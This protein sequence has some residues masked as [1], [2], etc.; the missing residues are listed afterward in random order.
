MI[1][2]PE[3]IELVGT[4]SFPTAV[5]LEART[6]VVTTALPRPR[7]VT[8][9]LNEPEWSLPLPEVCDFGKTRRACT[10]F[11]GFP[12]SIPPSTVCVDRIIEPRFVIDVS[13]LLEMTAGTS[14]L[15]VCG[16][17][18]IDDPEDQFA[19][20]RAN[21]SLVWDEYTRRGSLRFRLF[22]DRLRPSFLAAP[23]A[24]TIVLRTTGGVRV[25]SV[26]IP[27][28]TAE[29]QAELLGSIDGTK[30]LWCTGALPGS[31]HAPKELDVGGHGLPLRAGMLG[32]HVDVLG[33]PAVGPG[34]SVL[35]RPA[36]AAA[37]SAAA[38][39][40]DPTSLVAL[41]RKHW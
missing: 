4:R 12:P 11:P 2:E 27:P 18:V 15:H 9:A 10:V 14:A 7:L 29:V 34:P 3:V 23:Y 36:A 6:K 28:L 19:K 33:R 1:T 25:L 39:V 26:P 24:A 30:K 22:H 37:A 13:W 16:F 41:L 35:S 5:V 21:I 31:K 40:S 38:N 8:S 17:E 32:R 20:T